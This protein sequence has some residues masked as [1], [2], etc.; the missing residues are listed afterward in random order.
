MDFLNQT[1]SIKWDGFH[2]GPLSDDVW[3]AFRQVVTFARSYKYWKNRLTESRRSPPRD[4]VGVPNTSHSR[5]KHKNEWQSQIKQEDTNMHASAFQAA[6]SFWN[7]VAIVQNREDTPDLYFSQ[8]LM[9][10]VGDEIHDTMR[11]HE[12]AE[13]GALAFDS[14]DA[15]QE[16]SSDR[17]AMA[18]RWRK[19]Y[20]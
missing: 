7:I 17:K 14:F 11:G 16:I 18:A 6:R 4:F 1:P 20:L 5:R 12:R 3:A 10:A 19:A 15:A 9:I 13:V 2:Q 8:A